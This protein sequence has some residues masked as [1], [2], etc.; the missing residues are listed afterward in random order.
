MITR[1]K[2]LRGMGA[3]IVG[4]IG[5]TGLG[6]HGA[7]AA[8]GVTTYRPSLPGWPRDHR[9][10][11]VALA[12]IHA[13]EPFMPAER[14]ARIVAE[15][16]ALRPDLIVL[17]GDFATRHKWV[18]TP[19]PHDVWAR[20]LQA[21]RAP[22]GVLAIQG[23]HDMWVDPEFQRRR[24]GITGVRRALEAVGI[25]VLDNDAVRIANAGR[26]FWVAGLADQ[27]ALAWPRD[28]KARRNK[29]GYDGIDDLPGTLAKLTDDAP[30]ILLAHEPDIFP[31]VPSRISLTLSGHMHGGQV[32]LLGYA[33]IKP[34]GY[35][36][37]Y[38]YGHIVEEGRHLIV[39]GGLGCSGLPVRIA[40]PPEIVM[41][42]LGGSP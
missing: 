23:N 34:S 40:A 21:L 18:W 12:D 37:R 15:A 32:R 16:N 1:R 30:A 25:P 31:Q 38:I 33:P 11:I 28:S 2:I 24:S 17:L 9:L 5:L 13:N 36:H 42:E 8:A 7:A 29:F 26:P 10:R 22:L 6:I 19:L 4:G 14:I 3:T 39:S 27:W 20:E 35:G 41:V